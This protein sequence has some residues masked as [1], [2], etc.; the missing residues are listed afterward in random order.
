MS[1]TGIMCIYLSPKRW[2]RVQIKYKGKIVE[3]GTFRE[4]N[5]AKQKL[6][7]LNKIYPRN[8]WYDEYDNSI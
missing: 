8:R 4:L 6:E 5:A 3:G 2:Y 1:N 7:E